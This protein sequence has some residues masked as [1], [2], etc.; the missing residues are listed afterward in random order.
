MHLPA[1]SHLLETFGDHMEQQIS[2]NW[3][4]PYQD[5]LGSL[6]FPNKHHELV[7][8]LLVDARHGSSTLA[9]NDRNA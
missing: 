8:H 1:W 6:A 9:P 3:K 7:E 2:K 5:L 4:K